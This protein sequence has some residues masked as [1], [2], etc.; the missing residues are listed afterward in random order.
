[1]AL[2]VRLVRV[3]HIQ[4]S[5]STKLNTDSSVLPQQLEEKY[6]SYLSPTIKND[7]SLGCLKMTSKLG[8]VERRWSVEISLHI[9]S[10]HP[11]EDA[12]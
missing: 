6:I 5:K 10:M 2:V 8:E 4:Q 11:T 12:S 7:V 1:M 9:V 3:S